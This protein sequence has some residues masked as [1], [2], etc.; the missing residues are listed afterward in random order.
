M[1]L[2]LYTYSGRQNVMRTASKQEALAH[3]AVIEL[4]VRLLF[5]CRQIH[6]IEIH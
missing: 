6:K 3:T 1:F 2:A 5:S 4:H